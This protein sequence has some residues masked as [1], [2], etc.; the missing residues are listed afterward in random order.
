VASVELARMRES[1][2]DIPKNDA[3]AWNRFRLACRQKD[4]FSA[5]CGRTDAQRAD[6]VKVVD[7]A[8]TQEKEKAQTA[9]A[10]SSEGVVRVGGRIREPR[11][12]KHVVPVY[13]QGAR[14]ARIQGSVLLDAT[15]DP[16]GRIT[17]I[18]ILKSVP[19]LEPAAVEAVEQW[20][21]TPTL[22]DGRP[23]SVIMTVTV[24]FALQ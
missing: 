23:V 6:Y 18:R 21:Y 11:K 20:E 8:C 5:E 16:K 10:T 17:D 7:D 13:P 14:E 19:E 22:V 9:A 4:F 2:A 15:I 1:G 12:T 24:N 3:E